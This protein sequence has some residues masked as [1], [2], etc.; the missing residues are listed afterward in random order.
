MSKALLVKLAKIS[1]PYII[2]ISLAFGVAGFILYFGG[3]D[4]VS[5]YQTI[6]TASFWNFN[7]FFLTLTKFST[8][9]LMSLAFLVPYISR[10]F[11]IGVEGQYLMGALGATLVGLVVSAPAGVHVIISI[12]AGIVFGSL[13]ASVPAFLMSRYRVNEV[14]STIMM[15]FIARYSVIVFAMSLWRDVASGHPMT[16]PISA[17]ATLPLLNPSPPLSSAILF[18]ITTIAI[19]YFTITFTVFGYELRA[20]GTNPRA[21]EVFGVNTK[22]LMPLSLVVGG[23]LAGLG[24]ALDVTGYYYRLIDG[25]QSNYPSLGILIAL[26]SKGKI[27]FVLPVAFFISVI[28]VGTNALQRI[29][30]VPIELVLILEGLLLVFI[31]VSES[32]RWWRK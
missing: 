1:L 32:L 3:Y 29:Q 17:T 10:K 4:V 24:G 12:L 28:D 14:I 23:S 27:T 26:L 22:L 6:L 20:T 9:L 5:G 13:W 30:R 7:S 2:S 15:N 8:I 21:A 25:M 11:N 16:I 31:L 19:L 18:S